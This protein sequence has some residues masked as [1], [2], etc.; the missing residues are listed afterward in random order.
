MII[1]TSILGIFGI[2][3]SIYAYFLEQ[4]IKT[5]K[6]Y[7]PFCDISENVSC[8]KVVTSKY[9]TLFAISN[10]VWGIIFYS[11]IITA[12][13]F[14]LYKTVF[15]L[16]AFGFGGSIVLATILYFILKTVCLICTS[17]YIINI[18]LLITSYY[19]I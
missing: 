13:F 7:A 1:F 11:A 4:K 3:L 8:S 12:S 2:C 14:N 6:N 16:S 18:L 17:I 19:L 9:G 15:I 10:S 5:N